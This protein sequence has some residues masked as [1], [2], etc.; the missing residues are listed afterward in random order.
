MDSTRVYTIMDSTP[1]T[2]V[3]KL[4]AIVLTG[5]V[6]VFVIFGVMVYGA[7]STG[8][9][10]QAE[11]WFASMIRSERPGPDLFK[12]NKLFIDNKTKTWSRVPLVVL[13]VVTMLLVLVAAVSMAVVMFAPDDS[14]LLD[15]HKGE[16]EQQGETNLVP[17]PQKRFK[18]RYILMAV[19]AVAAI[20]AMFGGVF[21]FRSLPKPSNVV[22]FS[23]ARDYQYAYITRALNQKP[24]FFSSEKSDSHPHENHVFVYCTDNPEQL[25][26]KVYTVYTSRVTKPADA[27]VIVGSI[28]KNSLDKLYVEKSFTDETRILYF[29]RLISNS[30]LSSFDDSN[31]GLIMDAYGPSC[32]KFDVYC[33]ENSLNTRLARVHLYQALTDRQLSLP[34]CSSTADD[35]A[36]ADWEKERKF[37]F[38]N[39]TF[40]CDSKLSGEQLYLYAF[41]NGMEFVSV[42]PQEKDVA[43]KVFVFNGD[44]LDDDD[45]DVIGTSYRS[46]LDSLE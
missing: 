3:G 22:S 24:S 42:M 30:T 5:I 38:N 34:K 7:R 29:V 32:P 39:Q 19:A 33:Y 12:P 27:A 2:R 16:E 45:V 36:I 23:G 35:K 15:G 40:L 1:R 20:A 8:S 6:L 10:E 44:K 46:A 11:N 25:F 21:S 28:Y 26:A 4:V 31:V 41:F 18:K 13:T 43:F 37:S 17:F 9:L 14:H